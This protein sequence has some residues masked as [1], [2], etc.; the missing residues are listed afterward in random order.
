LALKTRRRISIVATI[1]ALIALTVAE[2]GAPRPASATIDVSGVNSQYNA[3]VAKIDSVG[4]GG[5]I[6]AL[7]ASSNVFNI[8]GPYNSAG[9]T[10]IN[11]GSESRAKGGPPGSGGTL[12]WD[13]N[14]T[15]PFPGS[16]VK[17]Y[18]DPCATLYHEF[19]HFSDYDHGTNN[20][21]PCWYMLNGT[22]KDSGIS[23][24]EVGATRAEN[25]YRS[26]Q[27][28]TERGYYGS[29]EM[30]PPGSPCIEPPPS[31]PPPHH[32][33]FSC[34]VRAVGCDTGMDFG[35]P[36][37][38]TLNGYQFD[39]QAV[40]EF[41]MSRSNDGAFEVQT[42]SQP[43]PG[44]DDLAL[45]TAVAV[46]IGAHR[47]AM[48]VLS[49][50]DSDPHLLR[51]DGRP[52][53]PT[54]GQ[55]VALPGGASISTSNGDSFVQMPTGERISLH[56]VVMGSSSF[57]NVSV[58]IPP[59][60]AGKYVGILGDGSGSTLHD[61]RTR[62]G[63]STALANA[64]GNAAG[65]LGLTRALPQAGVAF[66]VFVDR[67][68]ADSW[69]VSQKE[70]L[71]DYAPGTSTLTFTDRT[72]PRSDFNAAT[73]SLSSATQTCR[74]AGVSNILL[75]GCIVDVSAT[76][77]SVF[78]QAVAKAQSLINVK[79]G[80]PVTQLRA[81]IPPLPKFPIPNLPPIP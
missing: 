68:F 40:G 26:K 16:P 32:P 10:I 42:R 5:V 19:Q 21:N 24:A 78:A 72:F 45:N 22:P 30:P 36:H 6:N 49:K 18:E 71:F 11:P 23:V 59:T 47:L 60:R 58:T 73:A 52:I 31:P 29:H 77:S 2:F 14:S 38:V 8:R 37:I 7:K 80:S 20:E 76:K 48:Y 54:D 4:L 12:N 74:N 17:V 15:G 53:A 41:V 56:P 63:H 70:S 66:H 1:A 25:I 35:D 43:V 28:L 44:R 13:P 81:L 39:L 65:E 69:R 57:I 46:K 75:A 79:L 33:I 67:T 50:P 27:G 62:D 9:G 51:F 55:V 61:L 3:C 34:S 64:Y